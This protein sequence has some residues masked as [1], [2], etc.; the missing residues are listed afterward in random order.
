MICDKEDKAAALL[1]NKEKGSTPTLSCLVLF[2][3]FTEGLAT[4]AKACEVEVVKLEQLLVSVLEALD[5]S[6]CRLVHLTPSGPF[7]RSWAGRTSRILW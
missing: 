4:R 5:P 1:E 2:T 3:N 6:L 7:V